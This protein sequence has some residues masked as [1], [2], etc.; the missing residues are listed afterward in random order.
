MAR[1]SPLSLLLILVLA[2]PALLV[3]QQGDRKGHDNM[4]SIVPEELIPPAPFLPVTQALEQFAL[5]P[6]FVIEAVAAE[7]LVEMPVA[8]KFDGDGRM[9]VCE[10]K[11]Y[12]PNI[13]G[14]G[15]SVPQGRIA[16]LEDRDHDGKVDHR[17]VFL[18]QLLL[19]R[20]L[21]LTHDGLLFADQHKLYF[22][23]RDGLQP[24]GTPEVV[25]AGYASSG[26]VEHKANELLL[27]LDNWLYSAKSDRRYRRVAGKWVMER[28]VFR[29]Q[30][31]LTQDNYGR[32]YHNNNS[33]LLYGDFLLP[34]TLHGNP[35][36]KMK[37]NLA[38]RLGS[39]RVWPARVTPGLNRAYIS[40]LN[41]Y[42]QDTLDPKTFKLINTTA[43]CGPEVYRGD[44][45]PST[46][47]DLAFVCES[48]VNLVKAISLSEGPHSLRGDHPY[49]DREF[50]TST[51]ERFRPVNLY[52]APDGCLYL[53]D[54]YHG[55]I[56]HKTYVTSYLRQYITSRG[57]DKPGSGHGR[58]YRIRYQA[59]PRGP[60]PK[61]EGAPAASLVAHLG[62]PNGWWRDT[63]QHLLVQ[64][65]DQSLVPRL[66]KIL[67]A[68]PNELAQLHA[69]WTLEG[70]GALKAKHL[71]YLLQKTGK[72]QVLASV[73]TA[74][75]SLP[76]QDLAQ[77]EEA[78]LA[79]EPRDTATTVYRNRLLA[80][81]GTRP[82]LEEAVTT[83]RDHRKMRF[84]R[85]A[86][87]A[88]LQGRE[89]V[90][91]S[92]NQDRYQDKD[93]Q[94]WLA[95]SRQATKNGPQERKGPSLKGA[96]LAAFQKGRTLYRS[97][98]ACIGCHGEDGGGLPNLGPP[99]EKS[100]WVTGSEERLVKILLHGMHGPLE[101]AGE[102]YSPPAAM[103]GLV[104]NPTLD[105][106]AIA[107][108]ATYIRNEWGNRAS[109]TKPATVT[110]VRA[111]TKD[112]AG[113]PYTAKELGQ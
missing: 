28:T 20:A 11:G 35:G 12:M 81:L 98:A 40:R 14:E 21:C 39:N 102:K 75:R 100:E 105:D 73:L 37:G 48:G 66:E 17:T 63:A 103:P 55:I 62:H 82:A 65:G 85:E 70:L 58:I 8:L 44:N 112:R 60:A 88:G 94:K 29:G 97:T 107:A 76:P 74:A 26:N 99:L 59:N 71:R 52:T 16:V 27:G 2:G 22:I 92:V 77:L 23:K 78:L 108:I 111:E 96:H 95:S 3:A 47:Q 57:L 72:P 43:A 93:F 49:G 64:S 67:S 90:F 110:K 83:L 5:A 42:D 18:D 10:M 86:T 38:D 31:G 1:T 19:P 33:N 30:W 15:E 87:M 101:V 69:L 32:L 79:F 41:G 91:A 56:Q 53:L 68:P 61:M 6:G 46:G 13:D 109:P 54:M 50:L 24:V 104:A 84:L 4:S 45:F 9:W 25:D 51:D 36:A 80:T 113:R 106:K 89:E 34:N 7:P